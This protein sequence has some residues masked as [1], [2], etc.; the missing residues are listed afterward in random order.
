MY[1]AITCRMGY[2]VRH[3]NIR[4]ELRLNGFRAQ[5]QNVTKLRGRKENVHRHMCT[6]STV[7]RKTSVNRVLQKNMNEVD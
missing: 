6:R 1:V 3:S 5:E 2:I 4:I 7:E